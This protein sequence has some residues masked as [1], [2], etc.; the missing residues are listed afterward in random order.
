MPCSGG[1]DASHLAHKLKFEYGM[2]PL[3]VTWAPHL[4]T[5]IGWQNIHNLSRL[6]DL[7]NELA[8]PPGG[9]HRRLTKLSF[10]ILGDPFQPFIYGQTNYPLQDRKSTRLNSS[11]TDISRMP[12]SA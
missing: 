11:H 12:S 1:K 3:T 4:Y 9:I 7:A 6:G 8:T 10:E 5:D 2:N